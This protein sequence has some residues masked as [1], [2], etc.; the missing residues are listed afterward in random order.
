MKVLKRRYRSAKKRRPIP[1]MSKMLRLPPEMRDLL[2]APLGE[3]HRGRGLECV[4]KMKGDL[5]EAVMILAVGDITA[6]YLRAA[7]VWPDLMIVD[8]KTK[9]STVDEAVKAGIHH[10]GRG[11]PDYRTI[12]VDNPAGVLTNEFI[13][14]IRDCLEGPFKRTKIVVNGEEDL[15]TLPVILFAPLGSA[16]VY[17]QPGEGSVLVKVTD[18]K[19]DYI[20][21]LIDKMIVEE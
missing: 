21:S 4:D 13:H 20:K 11:S 19:K 6:Y 3:L 7:T 2:K 16:V 5:A 10:N 8:H 1:K 17:G 14:L 18:D 15:A 12:E 9:R